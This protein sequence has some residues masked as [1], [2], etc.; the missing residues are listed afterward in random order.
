VG[1]AEQLDIYLECMSKHTLPSVFIFMIPDT[2]RSQVFDSGLSLAA[3]S[4]Y[5][6]HLADWCRL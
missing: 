4:S 5:D 2:R 6:H 1:I 3:Q